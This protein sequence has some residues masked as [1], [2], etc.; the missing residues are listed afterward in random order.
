MRKKLNKKEYL[1][2]K[3]IE[4][5]QKK[6]EQQA[7]I[8]GFVK[9]AMVDI[10]LAHGEILD[11]MDKANNELLNMSNF[12]AN[13]KMAVQTCMKINELNKANAIIIDT[14]D[15]SYDF[16]EKHI[17][18]NKPSLNSDIM[19]PLVDAGKKVVDYITSEYKYGSIKNH[20]SK[21]SILSRTAH[22]IQKKTEE[23]SK[24]VCD[25]FYLN[26]PYNESLSE[27]FKDFAIIVSEVE[28]ALDILDE[29]DIEE[30]PT[31]KEENVSGRLRVTYNEMMDFA[32][33][34]GYAEV[35]QSA[36]THRIWRHPDTGIS[37]PIPANKGRLVPQGT[38]S[39][40]LRQM[41]LRRNDLAVYMNNK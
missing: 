17:L 18:Y 21:N 36:S 12:I 39:R 28:S 38:M 13:R 24:L 20:P 30:A 22:I 25:D 23:Y 8:D 19:R 31:T 9:E 29:E 35:R 11:A 1:A 3:K 10:D 27:A 40:M 15:V 4:K 26:N 14:Y 41:G 7:I 16:V 5:Q 6:E 37:L 2:V 33:H 34:M 32:K